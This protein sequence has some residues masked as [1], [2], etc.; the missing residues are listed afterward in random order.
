MG[1]SYNSSPLFV[2]VIY[3]NLSYFTIIIIMI[4]MSQRSHLQWEPIKVMFWEGHY[5]PYLILKHY[6]LQL[7]FSLFIYF[8]LNDTHII[9]PFSLYMN[10]FK[11]NFM[12]WVF[13]FNIKN[14]TC[15]PFGMPFNFDTPSQF[16]TP[17]ERIKILKVLLGIHHSHHPSSKIYC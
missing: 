6:V 10:T 15:L 4:A 2:H 14:A 7:T 17:L 3:L 9:G 16:N 13:I 5:S 12:W 1:I 11:L 8:H